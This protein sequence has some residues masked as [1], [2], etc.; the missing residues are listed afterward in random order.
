V[1]GAGLTANQLTACQIVFRIRNLPE[2]MT[3]AAA[4]VADI[5]RQ[6]GQ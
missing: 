1:Q 5:D 4:E 2:V 3:R 6:T